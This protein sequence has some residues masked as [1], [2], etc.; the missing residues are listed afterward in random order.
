[1]GKYDPNDIAAYDPPVGPAVDT[2]GA[3]DIGI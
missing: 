2:L 1:M 3:R